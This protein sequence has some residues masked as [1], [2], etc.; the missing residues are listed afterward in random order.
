MRSDSRFPAT[1]TAPGTSRSLPE[2]PQEGLCLLKHLKGVLVEFP[3]PGGEPAPTKLWVTAKPAEAAEP[4]D[5]LSRGSR[6]P[7]EFVS[8][9]FRLRE[10]I[11]FNQ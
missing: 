5:A 7:E 3:L 1:N 11:Y 2:S 4:S 6:R 10:D 8:Y 9:L